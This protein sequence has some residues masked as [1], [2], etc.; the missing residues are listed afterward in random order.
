[1]TCLRAIF[2][3]SLPACGPFL[4]APA[5]RIQSVECSIEASVG[6]LSHI[7]ISHVGKKSVL[8]VTDQP[9]SRR[10]EHVAVSTSP[11]ELTEILPPTRNATAQPGRSRPRR[12]EAFLPLARSYRMNGMPRASPQLLHSPRE[13]CREDRVGA[14]EKRAA[15]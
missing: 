5:F 11:R 3:V 15:S 4:P 10:T 7:C 1:M 12:R 2:H 8:L 9:R 13:H 6:P 14:G